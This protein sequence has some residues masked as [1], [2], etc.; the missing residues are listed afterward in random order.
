LLKSDGRLLLSVLN[1]LC[2]DDLRYAWW[3]R[4]LAALVFDGRYAVAGSQAPI[5][6]WRPSRLTREA[7][8]HFLLD[9]VWVPQLPRARCLGSVRHWPLAWSTRFLFLEMHKQPARA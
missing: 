7:W 6:R 8:P 4:G 9:R 3:W 1:P 5:T 2:R